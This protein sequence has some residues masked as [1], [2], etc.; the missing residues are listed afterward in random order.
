MNERFWTRDKKMG[1]KSNHYYRSLYCRLTIMKYICFVITIIGACKMRAAFAV[2]AMETTE[3][4]YSVASVPI[5]FNESTYSSTSRTVAMATADFDLLNANAV[6]GAPLK[7]WQCHCWNST[8]GL[9]V[10]RCVDSIFI[11]SS[12]DG[13]VSLAAAATKK[14]TKT[15]T[16]LPQSNQSIRN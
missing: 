6:D 15:E 12:S 3:H 13:N 10:G 11:L 16:K 4:N 5:D 9:E 7:G 1:K 8:N 14:K 2:T